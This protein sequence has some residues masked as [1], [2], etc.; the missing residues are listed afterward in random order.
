MEK[1]ER[2]VAEAPLLADNTSVQAPLLVGQPP[3]L[4]A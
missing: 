2:R 1:E 3:L 4:Q